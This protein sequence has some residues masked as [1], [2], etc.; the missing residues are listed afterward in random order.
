M[1]IDGAGTSKDIEKMNEPL[2][3]PPLV[4]AGRR[5][6]ARGD[7]QGFN[8]ILAQGQDPDAYI[9]NSSPRLRPWVMS[10][11]SSSSGMRRSIVPCSWA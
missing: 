5:C 6:R 7:D 1:G 3:P 4:N 11:K 8:G 9:L 2:A 10:M